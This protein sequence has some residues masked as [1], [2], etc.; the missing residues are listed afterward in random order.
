VQSTQVKITEF[1][2]HHGEILITAI[3]VQSN[4]FS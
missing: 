3:N 2:D 4:Y 1:A